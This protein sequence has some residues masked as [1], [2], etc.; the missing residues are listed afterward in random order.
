MR[1]CNSEWCEQDRITNFDSFTSEIKH[2]QVN[3]FFSIIKEDY[4][5]FIKVD[6]NGYG[7]VPSVSVCFKVSNN[8]DVA[9]FYK[10][11]CLPVDKLSCILGDKHNLALKCDRWSKLDNLVSCLANY[12]SDTVSLNDRVTSLVNVV[13]EGLLLDADMDVERASK[14]KFAL[15]QLDL[16]LA[17]RNKYSAELLI[18]AASLSY[19]NSG[20]YQSLRK[21]NMM[22]LPHHVYLRQFL[23]KIGP[24]S[25]G[26][27]PLQK[28]C[29]KE[30]SELLSDEEK[31]VAILL[32][33]IYVNS[34]LSYKA[35]KIIGTAE[36]CSGTDS[37][38]TMQAFMFSSLRSEHKDVIGLFPVKNMNSEVLL[39]LTIDVLK[40]MNELK[41]EV[42]CLISDNHSTN[43]KMFELLG[44]GRLK[45][46]ISN[47]AD[48]LKSL[49]LLFDSVHLLKCIR[50]NWLNRP[51][52]TFIIPNTEQTF[53]NIEKMLNVTEGQTTFE[54]SNVE[55]KLSDLRDLFHSE[56]S[57]LLKLAPSL[58]RKAL[59]PTAIE[60]QNVSL[61]ISIFDVKN[62][63]ALD[64]LKNEGIAISEG[65][66]QFLKL[67]SKW[68]TI[69]NVQHP[70]KGKYTR[71]DY[72]EPING[73]DDVKMHFW[74]I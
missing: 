4:V 39:A 68:W 73:L 35:G 59:Y 2:K 3:P 23:S 34:K 52:G 14:I 17:N 33:E 74:K 24:N 41:F 15:E 57:A 20:A 32:D 43:R 70:M 9:A 11:M 7:D 67:I 12:N 29:L 44:G 26:I 18:W 54:Y 25:P 64:M 66:I 47:P 6:D 45:T 56:N 53:P 1:K 22:T 62:T 60:R 30:K 71:N 51:N 50:N 36:N 61:A 21:S 38:T 46:C 58:S 19:S 5:L 16:S 37:A 55:A 13:K 69:C 65:T 40:L 8:L 28:S 63:V 27:G 48:P 10:N 31:V 42:V 49:F 72:A